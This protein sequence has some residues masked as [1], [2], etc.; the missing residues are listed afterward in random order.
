MKAVFHLSMFVL[1]VRKRRTCVEDEVVFE[2]LLGPRLISRLLPWLTKPALLSLSGEG[3]HHYTVQISPKLTI[4]ISQHMQAQEPY[5]LLLGHSSSSLTI[6]MKF[7]L[8]VLPTIQD[9]E[10]R[11]TA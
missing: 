5:N 3:S 1:S 2:N 9:S 10:H 8:L 7:K 11:K 4:S 6:H